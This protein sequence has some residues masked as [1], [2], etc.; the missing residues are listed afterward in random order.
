MRDPA[1]GVL[2]R[3]PGPTYEVTATAAY[4]TTASTR[5]AAEGRRP[6]SSPSHKRRGPLAVK[7]YKPPPAHE[8]LPATEA[9]P[10]QHSTSA[11]EPEPR[12]A[13]AP[14]TASTRMASSRGGDGGPSHAILYQSLNHDTRHRPMTA[15]RRMA[16]SRSDD[17]R[18]W[19]GAILG[20][21][22]NPPLH[23]HRT[24]DHPKK[25]SGKDASDQRRRGKPR[26][27]PTP[28]SSARIQNSKPSQHRRQPAKR[29]HDSPDS[30][31]PGRSRRPREHG[32]AETVPA[33]V[34]NGKDGGGGWMADTA[35]WGA[36]VQPFTDPTLSVNLL[37][38][39]PPPEIA[40]KKTSAQPS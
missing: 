5:G 12:H 24:P 27:T 23:R 39:P 16:S 25:N 20:S 8:R 17:G 36:M 21:H 19:N 10:C 9:E 4:E 22:M 15:S 2:A 26:A 34:G 40:F 3:K 14:T 7:S 1:I 30:H 6:L 13:T 32:G 37:L 35:G 28:T 11:Y 29:H 33:R 31:E 18:R 38:P